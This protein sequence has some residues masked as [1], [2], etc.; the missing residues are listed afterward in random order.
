[1]DEITA[2]KNLIRFSDPVHQQT[3]FG[4]K[5][6]P[7]LL[8]EALQ[9]TVLVYCH[10]GPLR[11]LLPEKGNGVIQIQ[12]V[13]FD[14]LVNCCS[15]SALYSWAWMFNIFSRHGAPC[16]C[17]LQ[18]FEPHELVYILQENSVFFTVDW[19]NLVIEHLGKELSFHDANDVVWGKRQE[20]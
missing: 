15:T 3:G 18:L 9:D 19:V 13:T 8:R 16:R 10:E 11:T 12:S 20:R 2:R 5:M 14:D 4:I 17:D 7:G 6:C 1:M